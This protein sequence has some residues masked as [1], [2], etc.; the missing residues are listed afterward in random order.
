MVPLYQ[1]DKSGFR[2]MIKA[3]NPQHQLQHKDYLI[4]VAIPSLYDEDE[5]CT[6]VEKEMADNTFYY[7]ATTDLWSSSTTEP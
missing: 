2:E 6:D 3:I 5:V 1:V 7:S 4:R